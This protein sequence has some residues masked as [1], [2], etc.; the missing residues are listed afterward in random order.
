MAVGGEPLGEVAVPALGAADGVREQAVVDEADPQ[1]RS[2]LADRSRARCRGE[3]DTSGRSSPRMQPCAATAAVRRRARAW[4]E[5]ASPSAMLQE[6]VRDPR[7]HRRT[8]IRARRPRSRSDP[9][10]RRPARAAVGRAEAWAK[11]RGGRSSPETE[12]FGPD[13]HPGAQAQSRRLHLARTSSTASAA[14][15]ST[16]ANPIDAA[17]DEPAA[18]DGLRE[19]SRPTERF[20]AATPSGAAIRWF[21]RTGV[22]PSATTGPSGRHRAPEAPRAD[23]RSRVAAAWRRADVLPRALDDKLAGLAAPL[24]ALL[25][26][27][28]RRRRY[29]TEKLFDCLIAGT[30]PVYLGAP[31]IADHVPADCFVDFRRLGS[32]EALYGYL[33][34]LTDD[35]FEAIRAAGRD[36]LRSDRARPFAVETWVETLAGQIASLPLERGKTGRPGHF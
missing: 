8:C 9:V 15:V 22:R 19:W 36:F 4:T 31:D 16:T 32:Y 5:G 20:A 3:N 18:P 33:S 29:I 26:E 11:L 21:E 34:S 7:R 24:H 12:V 17:G 30:I 14:S 23:D 1:S 35:A 28:P 25:R 6:R 10:P 27:H 13:W 2:S